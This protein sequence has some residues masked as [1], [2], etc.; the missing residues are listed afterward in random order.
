MD[1]FLRILTYV[2]YAEAVVKRE[3]RER[4]FVP[5]AE[6]VISYSQWAEIL[7]WSLGRTRRCFIRLMPTAVSNW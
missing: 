4:C 7:G 3:S 6:S 5:G 2:N 1:A